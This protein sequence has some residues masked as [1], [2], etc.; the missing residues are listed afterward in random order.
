MGNTIDKKMYDLSSKDDLREVLKIEET[1]MNLP[2]LYSFLENKSWITY[3]GEQVFF[4]SINGEY[5]TIKDNC[6]VVARLSYKKGVTIKEPSFFLGGFKISDKIILQNSDME[7]IEK[8]NSMPSISFRCLS[9]FFGKINQDDSI[10]KELKK[11]LPSIELIDYTFDERIEVTDNERKAIKKKQALKP[12]KSGF[13]LINNSYEN[14]YWH[15][16]GFVLLKIK[17]YYILLGQDEGSYFGVELSDNFSSCKKKSVITALKDLM[18]IEARNKPVLRQGEW[19]AVEV[20]EKNVPKIEKCMFFK[21][22]NA[23]SYSGY[24][25]ISLPVD[26][27]ESSTHSFVGRDYRIDKNGK[28]FVKNGLLFHLTNDG[29]SEHADL[30]LPNNKWYTFYKN[31]AKRSFSEKG[32]D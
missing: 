13:S 21:K 11:L 9:R 19:F 20:A 25:D 22:S 4:N 28:I 29:D 30:N 26:S 18:P 5:L 2:N 10:N 32:V 14:K 3:K 7:D 6:I 12:P 24:T 16:S 8:C 31:T 27:A 23:D 15:R 1:M 17:D